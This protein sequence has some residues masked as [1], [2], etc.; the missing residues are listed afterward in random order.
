MPTVVS[1]RL[2]ALIRERIEAW[3]GRKFPAIVAQIASLG[4]SEA[5][6][7]E[8]LILVQER[9]RHVRT[10]GLT[11]E[12]SVEWAG[13]SFDEIGGEE[14]LAMIETILGEDAFVAS[15]QITEAVP[16]PRYPRGV[17]MLEGE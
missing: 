1:G 15:L 9:Q 2:E 17:F 11:V 5:I 13:L 3:R 10:D 8:R 7:Y 14:K 6:A 16:D 4:I 12:L